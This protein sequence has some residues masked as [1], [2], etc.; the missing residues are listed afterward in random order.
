MATKGANDADRTEVAANLALLVTL[1]VWA[2]GAGLVIAHLPDRSSDNW[3]TPASGLVLSVAALSFALVGRL[4]V[5]HPASRSAGWV[6]LA[7]GLLIQVMGATDE[8]S[9][10][11]LHDVSSRVAIAWAGL[12]VGVLPLVFPDGFRSGRWRR[13]AWSAG[14]ATLAATVVPQ[15]AA[16][17]AVL[18]GFGI[19]GLVARYRGSDRAGRQQVRWLG[20]GVTVALLP[21][22]VVVGIGSSLATPTPMWF[23]VGSDVA[24]IFVVAIPA[25]IGM[26][27]LRHRLALVDLIADR[28]LVVL[29]VATFTAALYVTVLVGVGSV[30][31]SRGNVWLLVLATV[32][33]V[34]TIDPVRRAAERFA[35]RLVYGRTI[36][37][38]QLLT[39]FSH[40]VAASY[41]GTEA[42]QACA[43]TAAAAT[44]APRAATWVR[45]GNHWELVATCPADAATPV[46]PTDAT[47]ALVEQ[48]DV[49]LGAITVDVVRLLPDQRHMLNDLAASSAMLFR[50]VALTADLRARVAELA[51]QAEDLRESRARLVRSEDRARTRIERN[52]HDGAQQRLVA[53]SISLQQLEAEVADP[54][55]VRMVEAAAT[56]LRCA[57]SELRDIAR[58]IHPR[59][60]VESGLADAIRSLLERTPAPVRLVHAPADRLDHNLEVA[61][62]YVVAEALTNAVKHAPGAS[63]EV[64]V[65]TSTTELTVRVR[66]EG[67]GGADEQGGSGLRGL[68]DRIASVGGTLGV[69]SPA[70]SGTEIE[71]VLPCG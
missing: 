19:A 56:E 54:R 43:D 59:L 15:L 68:R 44:G 30:V 57:L 12:A 52:L 37:P 1:G 34:L 35:H 7:I 23:R 6:L 27:V 22:V 41:S 70:G 10:E 47:A 51:T 21:Q 53:L 32:V 33:L 55:V 24:G 71:A 16:V 36:D 29:S 40:R 26:A 65:T 62:Y 66:D 58:G 31:G 14:A 49:T 50:T 39:A 28:A 46:E 38:Y 67:P 3:G 69:R 17:L 48:G 20:L 5:T 63:I 60:L 18:L 61:A 2:V 45:A 25:A 11:W 42:L 9:P 8:A 64:V 4:V 13:V